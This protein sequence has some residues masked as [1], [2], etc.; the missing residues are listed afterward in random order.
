MQR[1]VIL[2]MD[3]FGIGATADAARF[4]DTG[5]D[6]L[7]HIAEACAAGKAD[8]PGI[9]QGPLRLPN[10]TR[11]GLA[12]AAAGSAGHPPAGLDAT[13]PVQAAYGYAAEVSSG[14]DTPSGHW[15][16][17]GLPVTFDWGVFP[18]TQPSFPKDLTD[19]LIRACDLPGIL[20]NCHASGTDIIRALGA[21]HI[22]TGKPIC[23]TSADSVFQIAAHETHFGLQRLYDMCKVAKKLTEPL[24]VARVIARPFIGETADDFTRTANRKDLTTPPHGDTLL[25]RLVAEGGKVVAIGKIADIYA[26]GGISSKIAA[27]DNMALFDATLAAVKTAGDRTLIFA[28]LVD[29]DMLYGHRRDIAGYAAALEAL[30]RRLPELEALLQPDDIVLVTADHGCDPTWHGSDHTREHVP[31][32]WFGPKV[33]PRDLGLRASFADMGQTLAAHFDIKPL[34]YGTAC[35]LD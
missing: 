18:K 8:R 7:G 11:L 31:M 27:G 13:A 30:D 25:T 12:R 19:A 24:N 35:R 33:K 5:A 3:S 22:R 32:L 23:Y 15:E 34:A 21:E 28:N 26:Y 16:I 9:R 4:G 10:L 6:T 14:K 2:V 1:G 17:A 20:G 29:F